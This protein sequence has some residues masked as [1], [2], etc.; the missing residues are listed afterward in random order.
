MTLVTCVVTRTKRTGK[1]QR[2]TERN[3]PGWVMG[4]DGT[5]WDGSWP[6]KLGRVGTVK[7]GRIGPCVMVYGNKMR[8]HKM[9]PSGAEWFGRKQNGERLDV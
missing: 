8:R 7:I 4:M 5:K 9:D 2:Q 6:F 3:R 1:S